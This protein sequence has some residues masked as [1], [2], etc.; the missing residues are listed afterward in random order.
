M[1]DDRAAAATAVRSAVIALLE[2]AIP[3]KS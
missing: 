1:D 2:A 3:E